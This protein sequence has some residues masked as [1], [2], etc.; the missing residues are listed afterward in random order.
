M[1]INDFPLLYNARAHFS[2]GEKYPDGCAAAILQPGREGH[3]ALL[4]VL[5]VLMEE[6]ELCR[7]AAEIISRALGASAVGVSACR[8]EVIP[9]VT[10]AAIAEQAEKPFF[11]SA[12]PYTPAQLEQAQHVWEL[13]GHCRT[14]VTV[15]SD[16]RGVGG[17]DSWGTDVEPAYRVSGEEDHCLRFRVML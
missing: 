15:A 12:I 8:F 10:A 9:A 14:T 5:T 13:P 6:A 16:M 7:R 2:L 17:I 3:G 4:D 1:K 11:F